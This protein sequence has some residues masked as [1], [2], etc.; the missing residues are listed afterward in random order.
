[1]SVV[2]NAQA[3]LETSSIITHRESSSSLIENI[4]VDILLLH[5][6]LFVSHTHTQKEHEHLQGFH[7]VSHHT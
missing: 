1:M 6:S 3:S 5:I 7:V 4:N 2:V